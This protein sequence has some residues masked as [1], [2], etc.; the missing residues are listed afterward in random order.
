MWALCVHL[1]Q[2]FLASLI[3]AG[4]ILLGFIASTLM[5]CYTCYILKVYGDPELSK[6]LSTIFFPTAFAHFS[7]LCYIL[8][9]F[10]NISNF[11]RYYCIYYGGLCEMWS[12]ICGQRSLMLLLWLPEDWWLA[13]F[14]Q[15]SFFFFFFFFMTAPAAYGSSR[16]RDWIWAP[17]VTYIIAV[18]MPDPLTHCIGLGIK[19]TLLQQPE[20]L[21]SDS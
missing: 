11:V 20:P 8:V 5:Y 16:A 7:S 6:S 17:A 15:W 12:V 13:F 18:A 9:I 4:I 14:L 19:P 21:Q 2:L 10:C 3:Q 1:S